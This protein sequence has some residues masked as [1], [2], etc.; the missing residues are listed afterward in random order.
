MD[1]NQQPGQSPTPQQ[2][3]PTPV[4]QTPTSYAPPVETSYDPNYLDSIAAAPPRA[5][6]LSGTFG[7]IFWV[8]IGVFVLAVSLIVAFSGKDDTADLQQMSV[9]LDNYSKSAKIV[10]AKLKSKNLKTINGVYMIWMNGNQSEAEGLLKTGGVSKTEYNKEMVR[11]ETK[12]AADLDEKF[13]DA[14]L[15]GTINRVYAS[16][17]AA[18]SEKMINLLNTMAKKSKS[19]QIR[20]FAQKASA[21]LVQTQKD[22]DSYTDDGN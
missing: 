10:D 14:R 20:E 15:A 22:F 18:E 3:A 1:P 7:K 21:S 16:T 5:S 4:P 2:P 17:M 13:E 11:K 19:K 8:L 12:I 9:R 6:F